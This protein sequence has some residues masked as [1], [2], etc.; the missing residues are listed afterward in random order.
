MLGNEKY[1]FFIAP[2][3]SRGHHRDYEA[4]L[5]HVEEYDFYPKESKKSLEDLKQRIVILFRK[6]IL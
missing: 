2:A 1:H 5:C 4:N 3:G 6:N